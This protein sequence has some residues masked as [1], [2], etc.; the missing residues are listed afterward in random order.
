[1]RYS[2]TTEPMQVKDFKK[3]YQTFIAYNIV[4]YIVALLGLLL[5]T[6]INVM[7]DYIVPAYIV[8][9]GMSLFIFL[10]GYLN[11]KQA[12]KETHKTVIKGEISRLGH[13]NNYYYLYLIGAKIEVGIT[14]KIYQDIHQGDKIALHIGTNNKI[15]RYEKI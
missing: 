7:K 14:A 11:F 2:E 4:A 8:T 10:S 5:F 15:L 9:V 6:K 12:L 3:Y 1:M 13:T